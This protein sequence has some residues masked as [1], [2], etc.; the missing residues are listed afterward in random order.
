MMMIL[1][2]WLKSIV[3]RYVLTM[4][5]M[6]VSILKFFWLHLLLIWCEWSWWRQNNVMKECCV[7]KRKLTLSEL[8]L[9]WTVHALLSWTCVLL[10]TCWFSSFKVFYQINAVLQISETFSFVKFWF[11][12]LSSDQI[13]IHLDFFVFTCSFIQ[14]SF[15]LVKLVCLCVFLHEDE[16]KMIRFETFVWIVWDE[17][18]LCH[19]NYWMNFSCFRKFEFV[20]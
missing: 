12:S 17:F 20:R 11:V 14:D 15:D 6:S 19:E 1:S 8:L 16:I 5:E 9:M 10:W 4:S 2:W 7:D 18:K 3:M 13:L